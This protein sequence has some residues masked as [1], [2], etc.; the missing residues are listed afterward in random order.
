[1]EDMTEE[2]IAER[3]RRLPPA[4]EAWVRAA[5][6]LP[7]ARELM[8]SIVARAEADAEYRRTVLADLEAAL[9]LRRRRAR[10][11][12]ARRVAA[13]ARAESVGSGAG[14]RVAARGRRRAPACSGLGRGTDR[15]LLVGDDSSRTGSAAAPNDRNSD[16]HGVADRRARR[17]LNG[18]WAGGGPPA[19]PPA[20]G[21]PL[22]EIALRALLRAGGEPLPRVTT[23]QV[24]DVVGVVHKLD[25][26]APQRERCLAV[27]CRRPVEHTPGCPVIRDL[28]GGARL[29]HAVLSPS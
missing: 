5:S 3:L 15:P 11:A 9:R 6:E 16:G 18:G 21:Q 20:S 1:M 8:D 19:T 29:A 14:P 13:P 24:S 10:D 22:W 25:A 4:P 28:L 27:I 12:A 7:R 2:E 23:G 26:R 17:P